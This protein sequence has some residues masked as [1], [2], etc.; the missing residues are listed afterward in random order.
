L[1]FVRA[2]GGENVVLEKALDAVRVS[3]G[4]RDKLKRALRGE[5]VCHTV[6]YGGRGEGLMVKAYCGDPGKLARW[7]EGLGLEAKVIAEGI[8]RAILTGRE[9]RAVLKAA[10]VD[11]L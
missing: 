6:I 1:V 11:G 10:G 8:P 5:I 7:L 9:A 2:F 3:Q 4:M